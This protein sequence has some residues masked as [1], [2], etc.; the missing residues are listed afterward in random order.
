MKQRVVDQ[1]LEEA[2]IIGVRNILALRGDPPRDDEYRLDTEGGWEGEEMEK[3]SEEFE[4]AIDL[5]KYIRRRYGNFFCIGVATYPEGHTDES[6]SVDQSY[7]LDLPHLIDKVRAGADFLVTQFFFDVN[8]YISFEKALREHESGV[9]REL[10]IICG[11][12]PIQSYQI[13]KRTTK[14][15]HCRIP[16]GLL[17]AL[18]PIKADDERVKQKGISALCNIIQTIRA[19]K[20]SQPRG[21]HFY[22]LNLEKVVGS[23]LE[24]CNLIPPVQSLSNGHDFA[25][26]SSPVSNGNDGV[27]EHHPIDIPPIRNPSELPNSRRPS[28]S[29]NHLTSSSCSFSSSHRVHTSTIQP[30]TTASREATW[31]DYPNGRFGDA[32][33]PAFGTPTSYSP[34]SLPCSPARARTLWGEP[35]SPSAITHLFTSHLSGKNPTQLPWSDDSSPALSRETAIIR[36]HLLT[37]T[38]TRN[39]LTIASQPAVDGFL[40]TDSIHGWG[41]AKGFVFQKPFVEF[42]CA[43]SDWHYR[44]RPY[45]TSPPVAPEIS[46]YAGHPSGA[47]ETS[48]DRDAVHAVTWGSFLGQEITTATMVEEVSFQAWCR[49]AFGRWEEWAKCCRNGKAREF[50]RGWK[51]ELVLIN[52][53]GHSYQQGEG[54][55][56]W[57]ILR[58]VAER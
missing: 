55:R 28:V 45:L 52:V 35:I 31:D 37:L 24:K 5:V 41:P 51:E 19:V 25:I 40:S 11:L 7:E 50:L 21:F 57:E 29:S 32:R 22:T 54:T 8:A 12:L 33:S 49:E 39:W 15:A 14:L 34:Y 9:F 13:L 27:P 47:F 17:G 23:I 1:A 58:Q 2:K 56:L 48:E 44:L 46:Y 42:F 20:S 30:I 26:D 16:Q 4:W 18:E 6:Q 43:S 36:D 53:I 3:N 10:P 38:T